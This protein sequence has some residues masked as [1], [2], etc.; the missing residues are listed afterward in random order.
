MQAIL[1]DCCWQYPK[2]AWESGEWPQLLGK[3]HLKVTAGH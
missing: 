3:A 2:G 1:K